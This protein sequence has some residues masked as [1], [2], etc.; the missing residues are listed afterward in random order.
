MP[1]RP[2][3]RHHLQRD[4]ASEDEAGGRSWR[5]ALPYCWRREHLRRTARIS[6]VVGVVLT[7]INQL[8]VMLGR[9]RK[10]TKTASWAVFG[11]YRYETAR[12]T[13]LRS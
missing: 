1:R 6:L 12:S 13:R 9:R 8:D 7:S 4:R 10:H 5:A 3:W 11:P 2:D